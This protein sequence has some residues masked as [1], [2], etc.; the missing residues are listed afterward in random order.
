MRFY[1]FTGFAYTG[2]K[3][4]KI[5]TI[6]PILPCR[7][8]ILL[9]KGSAVDASIAALLCVGLMNAHSMGIGGGLFLTIYNAKT[10]IFLL[11]YINHKCHKMSSPLLFFINYQKLPEHLDPKCISWCV[12]STQGKLRPLMPGRRRHT[13]QQRT[14]LATVQIYP[15]KVMFNCAL[16]DMETK[17]SC[18]IIKREDGLVIIT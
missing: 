11:T 14:C 5:K 13:M 4:L 1:I 16:S 12:T 9:K 10:G 8:D 7:R 3:I 18:N 17:G 15:R 2:F 6:L